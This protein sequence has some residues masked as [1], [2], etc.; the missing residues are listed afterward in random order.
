MPEPCSEA[1]DAAMRARCN[2]IYTDIRRAV[3]GNVV[4]QF[5]RTEA[6]FVWEQ[7][8]DRTGAGMGTHPFGWS[9]LVVLIAMERF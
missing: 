6:Q 9:A 2:E 5:Q 7:Y 3:L 1:L 8:D 4:A